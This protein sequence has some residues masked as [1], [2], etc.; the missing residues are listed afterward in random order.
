MNGFKMLFSTDQNSNRNDGYN[1]QNF[2]GGGGGG[3]GGDRGNRA[4]RFHNRSKYVFFFL[5]FQ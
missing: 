5:T 2:G 3:G 1:R 4:N